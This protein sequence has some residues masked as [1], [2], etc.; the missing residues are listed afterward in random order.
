MTEQTPST[1]YNADSIQVLEGKEAV[2]K[3]PGMYIGNTDDGSGLHHMVYEVVDN[4]IDEALAGHCDDTRII[5]HTD[6]SVSVSDNGRGMPVG[7]HTKE[8]RS[9]AEVIMTVLHAGGKFDQNSYK[10]SGGLH[11]VGVSVVNFLSEWLE[12]EV[13]RD[14]GVWKQRYERGI[15]TEPLKK[16]A[17]TTE[18]GTTVRFKPDAEIFTITT[19]SFE[20]LTQRLKELSYLNAGVS[21]K[22]RDE[23]DDKEVDFSF[24]GGISSFVVDLNKNKTELHE[25][26]VYII[27]EVAEEGMT[28]ELGLQ[29]NDSYNENIFCYTNNIRNRDGGTHLSGLRGA[30]TRTI[31]TYGISSGFL[32]EPL[33]GDDIREGLTSV[34]SV[35]MPDPKFSSQ[36]KDKLV[37]NE[38]KGVVEGVVNEQ[39]GYFL[40]ENPKLAK[41][42]CEKALS[43][44]RAREAAR[45]ARDIARKSALTISALPGKLSDCQSRNPEECEIYI[46]EG[47]SAGGSAKQGRDRKFQA[48]LPLRGKILNVERA[49][50]DR[51][52]ASNEI[53]TLISA[54]GCGIGKEFFNIEKLR[55]HNII[56]MTDADVDGSHIRVLLL[57]FFYRQM[58]EII[59]KGY[60]YIAQPPL[61][62]M[63]RGK[64]M[65]YIKDES[66]L[67]AFLVNRAVSDLKVKGVEAGV[68]EGEELRD[69]IQ[70][71]LS[72]QESNT[73][74]DRRFDILVINEYLK[75]GISLDELTD[76]KGLT[77]LAEKVRTNLGVKFPKVRWDQPEITEND[78]GEF[79]TVWSTRVSGREVKTLI[80]RAVVESTDFELL[81]SVWRDMNKLGL[82]V[83]VDDGK[84]VESFDEVMPLLSHLLEFGKKG[85]SIQRYK[86]LGEMNPGQLWETTMDPGVRSLLQVR[87]ED[88]LQAD[89]IFT[90]LMGDM[91]EPRREFIE[92]NA[93]SVRNLDV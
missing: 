25:E 45:K 5:I 78:R 89:E 67:N 70:R 75:I 28:V 81:A 14:G 71:L 87:I 66:R 16:V 72:Y 74:L 91:V 2:R 22:V 35:K 13:R 23:R 18:K 47:D 52:L 3:R 43:A 46:V 53:S 62:G 8:K 58:P 29:W 76:K 88:A 7:M 21:I 26:P 12:L 4:A 56:L 1:D 57:T 54:L 37:S 30:L 36:T 49:R 38:V 60:L 42:I 39:L 92:K 68:L 55:Y 19:F 83:N 34:L 40:Q 82:P 32:K 80:N 69:F 84:N 61:Y 93:L 48:I 27:K 41:V 77:E 17:D 51:M 85:Q 10:V 65:T 31:N 9:A 63:K 11:G 73:K 59:E 79:D 90:V 24:A 15:P 44:A 64:K 33:S 50:F 6:G 20:V 86:G